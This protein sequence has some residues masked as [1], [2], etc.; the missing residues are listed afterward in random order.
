MMC[1]H[2]MRGHP[3]A[4][5]F[6]VCLMNPTRFCAYSLSHLH[7]CGESVVSCWRLF[8]YESYSL[9]H[10]WYYLRTQFLPA[11]QEVELNES[12]TK[13]R[14]FRWRPWKS[15]SWAIYAR[16]II[17][18][19]SK[20]TYLVVLIRKTLR[21]YVHPYLTDPVSSAPCYSYSIWA[22]CVDERPRKFRRMKPPSLSVWNSYNIGLNQ[23]H[24]QSKTCKRSFNDQNTPI[25]TRT[26]TLPSGH[27][28]WNQIIWSIKSHAKF[29]HCTRKPKRI[30]VCMSMDWRMMSIIANVMLILGKAIGTYVLSKSCF[31]PGK[32]PSL[33]HTQTVSLIHIC[34][35]KSK[36][37]PGTCLLLSLAYMSDKRCRRCAIVTHILCIHGDTFPVH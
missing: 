4:T 11:G 8:H 7:K 17:Q 32:N 6:D 12:P 26:R 33:L 30:H 36:V 3:M 18:R 24:S 14:H 31:R 23:Q 29:L 27:A 35:P 16:Y 1:K 21:I 10:T 19:I 15:I 34:N 28:P 22:L 2:I 9:G 13:F 25:H 5:E 20:A 37:R